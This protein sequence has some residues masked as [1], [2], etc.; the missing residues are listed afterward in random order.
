MYQNEKVNQIYFVLKNETDNAVNKI[1]TLK[2]LLSAVESSNADMP[3]Y[4]QSP[5]GQA[6]FS[7][8]ISK[9]LTEKVLSPIG[10]KPGT[11]NGL[12][13]KYRINMEPES[14][15]IELAA[16]VIKSIRPP[17]MVDY[18]IGHPQ[19]FFADEDVIKTICSFW[20][21]MDGN[22]KYPE[23]GGRSLEPVSKR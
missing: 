7:A 1:I 20:I 11:H 4:L 2:K 14:K 17:A 19:D 3:A 9:L 10:K 15:N 18:Y 23:M 21:S 6:A 22:S 8:V 13:L 12:H 16:R 5:E